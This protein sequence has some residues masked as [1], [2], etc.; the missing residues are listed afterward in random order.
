MLFKRDLIEK[1]LKG[2]KTMT[3]RN[4]KLY[5]AGDVTNLMADKDFSKITG[6]YIKILRV[7]K[8]TLGT[9]T[10]VDAKKEGFK[11]LTELKRYW[12]ENK[13]G[14]WEPE[15]IVWVHE[16]KKCLQFEGKS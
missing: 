2:E 15:T 10:N 3:S 7:Y 8:K 11:D 4:K 16:F 1:I 13:I 14:C 12:I 5:N 6:Y 9:F